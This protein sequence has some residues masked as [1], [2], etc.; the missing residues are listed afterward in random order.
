MNKRRLF[1]ALWPTAQ[2]RHSIVER[3]APF[4]RSSNEHI[5]P[6][7]NL[8][9]T[10]HFIGSVTKEKKDCLHAAAQTV[11]SGRFKCDLD[12]FDSFLKPRVFWMGCSV[13][14][15]EFDQLHKKLANALEYCGY[16]QEPPL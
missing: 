16:Q 4:P 11:S 5:V 12:Y 2:L 8:H 1:F 14:P 9:M 6:V 3:L 15:D 7:H 13:V 10:L